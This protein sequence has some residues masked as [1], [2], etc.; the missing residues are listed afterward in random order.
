MIPF[1]QARHFRPGRREPETGQP[2]DVRAI[3]IHTAEIGESL[4]G[5][6]ALQKVCATSERVASW[7]FAI[8]ENSITQSVKEEDTAFHAPGLS[9]ASIG[10]EHA[11][12]ARQTADEWA[13]EFSSRM[14]ERSAE[15]VAQLCHRHHVTC[16]RIGV[17]EIRNGHAGICGHV[18]V[19]KAFGKSDH[20]DPG[21][22]FPW[23]WYMTRVLH[24]SRRL[25][26]NGQPLDAS[27]QSQNATNEAENLLEPSDEDTQPDGSAAT[28]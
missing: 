11:G 4:E 26:E 6:E 14:L 19:S 20:Y 16:V 12:R 1:L 2:C 27:G 28:P 24:H 9:H 23:D 22:A 15:L 8:D 3:V 25:D 7:H 21:P 18:D 5:A 17:E 13:D 10:I